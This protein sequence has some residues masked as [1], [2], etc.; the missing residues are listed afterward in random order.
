[1]FRSLFEFPSLGEKVSVVTIDVLPSGVRV[2]WTEV[3]SALGR[4]RETFLF[5]DLHTIVSG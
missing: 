5:D 4:D 1:V 3:T 2:E